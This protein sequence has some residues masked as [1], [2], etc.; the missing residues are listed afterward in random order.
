MKK[1]VLL[2]W[3]ILILQ[4]TCPKT[5]ILSHV[6]TPWPIGLPHLQTDDWPAW[7][8]WQDVKKSPTTRRL[9]IPQFHDQCSWNINDSLLCNVTAELHTETPPPAPSIP[10]AHKTYKSGYFTSL[11]QDRCVPTTPR[12]DV[13]VMNALCSDGYRFEPT[14]TTLPKYFIIVPGIS[15]KM[16]WSILNRLWISQKVPPN[17]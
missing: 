2:T 11:P 8:M 15:N 6:E 12:Q 10:G 17:S 13:A 3:L 16:R 7:Q 14:A 5:A 1:T 9:Q 4:N